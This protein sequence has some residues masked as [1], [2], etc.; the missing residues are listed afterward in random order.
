[1]WAQLNLLGT[2]GTP[3]SVVAYQALV[4]TA[5]NDYWQLRNLAFYDGTNYS[6][7]TAATTLDPATIKS[8][9]A[10]SL[11]VPV[12][13]VTDLQVQAEIAARSDAIKAQIAA[14]LN[15]AV[16][17]ITD[18]QLAAEVANRDLG[19]KMI[20][21]QLAAKAGV[22]V[23]TITDNQVELEAATRFL[24]AQYL[25]GIKTVADFPASL[26]G[27]DAG[28]PPVS[29]TTLFGASTQQ[30][31]QY[32]VDQT[33]A[34][35]DVLAT[36]NYDSTFRFVLP[37]TSGLYQKLASGSQWTLDQLTYTVS[38]GANPE[39]NV[40][41]TPISLMDRNVR[42]QQ[43]MLYA[44]NGTIGSLAAPEQFTFRSD[45]ASNL[46]A[47]QKALLASAGPGQL[48]VQVEDVA[49]SNGAIKQY[50][51]TIA[52]QSLVVIDPY[53]P[54]SALAQSQIYLGSKTNLLLGGIPISAYGPMT[55]AYAAGVQTIQSGDVRLQAGQ[56]ILGGVVNQ[57][58]IS[59]N[60]ANLTLIADTG[61][62]GQ[63]TNGDPALNPNALLL[64]LTGATSQFDQAKA[65]Q[66]IY[67]RQ[68]AGDLVVGNINAGSGSD[69]ALQ[70]GATGSIYA[71][72][73]F[74][75]RSTVHIVAT[76]L[77]VRAGGSVSFN[78]GNFQPLQVKITGAITG[79][80]ADAMTLLSPNASMMIGRAGDY[81]TLVVGGAL[82]L[83]TVGDLTIA[84]NTTA[85]G[86]LQLLANGTVMFSVGTSAAPITA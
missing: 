6:A 47:A 35:H 64:A 48:T 54:V 58:A 65:A 16:T 73:Q 83:D 49:G 63:A 75:D 19:R 46:T 3:G 8:Q 30:A 39:N 72:S 25:L 79:L 32:Q 31:A 7:T 5:Y 43:V 70:L 38:P 10:A 28:A 11:N 50:T 53:G 57:V 59:G 80:A 17:T 76:S 29:L 81:G 71:E 37:E 36:G 22:D 4:N 52:Q 13:D 20:A 77:D 33:Q 55:A 67:I 45:N 34:L 26:P 9:L 40:P 69:S 15:V 42:G 18:A 21:A 56:S 66:G 82:T 44:P 41:A 85:G 84:A 12:T 86:S 78:Q 24:K 2:G 61:S 60:I 74:T 23:S 14:R 62:I 68:T 1:M 51:V 27:A